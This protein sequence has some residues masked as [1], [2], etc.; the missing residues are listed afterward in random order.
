MSGLRD[1]MTKFEELNHY[2]MKVYNSSS[3]RNVSVQQLFADNNSW[4]V[5]FTESGGTER[6]GMRMTSS[7]V[8]EFGNSNNSTHFVGSDHEFDGTSE[9]NGTV[10]A[11]G[12]VIIASPYGL[13]ITNGNV[14]LNDNNQNI[15][16]EDTG[17]T[18]RV[19]LS[20]NTSN[21]VVLGNDITDT[22]VESDG[23]IDF[24]INGNTEAQITSSGLT[25]DAD[26]VITNGDVTVNKSGNATC[27][28]INA[29]HSSF[30]GV[31]SRIDI[32]RASS[33]AYD[34]WRVRASG[35]SNPIANLDGAGDF[36]IDG[37]VSSPAA[38]IAEYAEWSDG[39]PAHEDRAGVA[40]RFVENANGKTMVRPARQNE[41]PDG[42]VSVMPSITG[43]SD[44]SGWQGRYQR[45]AFGRYLT[46]PVDMLA[47]EQ[48][49]TSEPNYSVK[50]RAWIADVYEPT[51]QALE[52]D[53]GLVSLIDLY[54]LE[55]KREGIV[56]R[57]VPFEDWPVEV[58]ERSC[59]ADSD[60]AAQAP[61]G[62]ERITQDERVLSND[63]DPS[64]VHV[65]RAN[66]KEWAKIGINGIVPVRNDQPT[67]ARWRKLGPINRNVTKWFI[68]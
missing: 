68:R 46:T 30:S 47:W 64:L 39:N 35:G 31:V 4:M 67:S 66:R 11:N 29:T 21:Q 3:W 12:N 18:L 26:I 63:F 41:D 50:A 40:V 17:G 37:S 43:G 60:E 13:S 5:T 24:D 28:T 15:A 42:V 27:H 59:R 52:A 10:T 58:V 22:L 19:S 51:K 65:P 25:V 23:D 55:R 45:D 8:V 33:S 7:N 62:A 36:S 16:I 34:V 1:G 48:E 61:D 32:D 9:F 56:P 38:D 57:I 49:V 53:E 14:S 6:N 44:W 20:L 2:L 54:V